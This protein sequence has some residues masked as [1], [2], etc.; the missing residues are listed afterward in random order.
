[1]GDLILILVHKSVLQQNILLLTDGDFNKYEPFVNAHNTLYPHSQHGLCCYHLINQAMS[2]KLG[3][4]LSY[5]AE[6]GKEL[7]NIFTDWVHSWTNEVETMAEYQLSKTPLTP[8]S[9]PWLLLK[10]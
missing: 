5:L 8:G 1:M 9:N 3:L 2:K 10:S 6:K 7:I 4:C